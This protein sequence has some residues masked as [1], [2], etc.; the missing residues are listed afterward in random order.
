MKKQNYK[1]KIASKSLKKKLKTFKIFCRCYNKKNEQKKFKMRPLAK[2][3]WYN[4][5]ES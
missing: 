3:T 1:V 4:G 2:N 5:Y